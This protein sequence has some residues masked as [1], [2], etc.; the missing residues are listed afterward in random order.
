MLS[1]SVADMIENNF[2][3]VPQNTLISIKN[4]GGL[5]VASDDVIKLCLVAEKIVRRNFPVG[6]KAGKNW[7]LKLQHETM[8]I[9]STI[10]IF[11]DDHLFTASEFDM[12]SHYSVLIKALLKQF[13]TIRINHMCKVKGI[14]QRGE[15]VR[16]IF[17]KMILFKGQ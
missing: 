10:S 7:I 5:C 16:Q 3:G 15:Q 13:F 4:Q 1:T 12:E 9:I 6:M 14:E 8:D 2:N 11:Q 17:T